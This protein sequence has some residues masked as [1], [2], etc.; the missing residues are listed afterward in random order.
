MALAVANRSCFRYGS[1]DSGTRADERDGEHRVETLSEPRKQSTRA[2]GEVDE[3]SEEKR[4]KT[5]QQKAVVCV[6]V[7]AR[8]TYFY[9]VCAHIAMFSIGIVSTWFR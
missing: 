2:L 6:C 1:C 3:M 4:Q 9:C 5:S 8:R 7:C